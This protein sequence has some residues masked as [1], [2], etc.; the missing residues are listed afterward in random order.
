MRLFISNFKNNFMIQVFITATFLLVCWITIISL[1]DPD[2]SISQSPRQ[3][4]LITAESAINRKAEVILVGSSL[5]ARLKQKWLP[6]NVSNIAL[7]GGSAL[8]GLEIIQRAELKPKQIWIEA[9]YIDRGIDDKFIDA[10]FVPVISQLRDTLPALQEKNRPFNVIMGLCAK[11]Q[12]TRQT[13]SIQEERAMYSD[14]VNRMLKAQKID[15]Q[16]IPA[17]LK[18]RLQQLDHYVEHF[19]NKG[20]NIVFF[21]MPVHPK[22][23]SMPRH[24]QILKTLQE[25]FPPSDGIKWVTSPNDVKYRTTDAL[26]LTPL[27]ARL[28]FEEGIQPHVSH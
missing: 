19:S 23:R 24:Q 18:S 14:T 13:T 15:Y 2:S 9:N 6:S 27:S 12:K 26:H 1:A 25:K 8:T 11:D 5:A 17:K 10:L 20:V 21:E 16:K 4:N 7:S 22:L 3:Y 28:F